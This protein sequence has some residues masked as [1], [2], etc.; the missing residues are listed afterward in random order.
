MPVDFQHSCYWV[1]L[2]W[3]RFC[4]SK[5]IIPEAQGHFLTPAARRHTNLFGGFG[6]MRGLSFGTTSRLPARFDG[7]ATEVANPP[8]VVKPSQGSG[9]PGGTRLL[10]TS[11]HV[12]SIPDANSLF[13]DPRVETSEIACDHA[14]DPFQ[15]L[16]F[17]CVGQ[18]AQYRALVLSINGVPKVE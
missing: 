11:V 10:L 3:S 13:V 7:S 16:Q 17:L 9:S 4:V 1:L 15:A 14:D 12:P 2:I 5:T 18:R 6:L 8:N